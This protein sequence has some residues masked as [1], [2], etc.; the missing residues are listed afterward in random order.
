MSWTRLFD[1]WYEMMIYDVETSTL[2]SFLHSSIG[3]LGVDGSMIHGRHYFGVLEH[4]VGSIRALGVSLT[5]N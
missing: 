5:G 2:D 3:G 4:L 1:P